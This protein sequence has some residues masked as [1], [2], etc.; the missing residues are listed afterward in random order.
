MKTRKGIRQ[1]S[2]RYVGSCHDGRKE[3]YMIHIMHF[4]NILKL[5]DEVIKTYGR[6]P[7][8]RDPGLQSARE[9]Y[10]AAF[11]ELI[12]QGMPYT[13]ETGLLKIETDGEVYAV[14]KYWMESMH[15]NPE[16]EEKDY[17]AH[18]PA[19]PV[20]LD[21]PYAMNRANDDKDLGAN[22]DEDLD[23]TM[24]MSFAEIMERERA[25]EKEGQESTDE[26]YVQTAN[27][28]LKEEPEAAATHDENEEAEEESFQEAGEDE[29]AEQPLS[30]DSPEDRRK[31]DQTENWESEDEDYEEPAGEPEDGGYEGDGIII[32]SEENGMM[33][34]PDTEGALKEQEASETHPYPEKPDLEDNEEA[35]DTAHT[36]SGMDNKEEGFSAPSRLASALQDAL[37]KND[38]TYSNGRITITAPNGAEEKAGILSMPL[39]LDA[40]KPEFLIYCIVAGKE[41]RTFTAKG[42]DEKVITIAGYRAVFSARIDAE[43]NYKTSCRLDEDSAAVG[44]SLSY[45]VKAGGKGG[46]IVLGDDEGTLRIHAM[47]TSFKDTQGGQPASVL[48]YVETLDEESDGIAHPQTPV[49]FPYE[50]GYIRAGFIWKND[51]LNGGIIVER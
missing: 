7:D 9:I 25:D 6:Y 34:G 12:R 24:V 18:A 36:P 33:D 37:H 38:F 10:K 46:H 43:G 41:P 48:Y 26:E 19:V 21:V 44:A 1:S 22:D 23:E 15:V 30:G 14:N 28:L 3:K 2:G 11:R 27:E 8:E 35:E 20:G 16:R 29:E 51:V 32:P 13:G 45:R 47:P 40:S 4:M 42:Q 39:S 31:D 17:V 5:S 50:D 49:R